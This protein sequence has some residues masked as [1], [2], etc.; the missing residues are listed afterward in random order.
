MCHRYRRGPFSDII[1]GIDYILDRFRASGVV[2]VVSMSL[3]GSP[4][5]AWDQAVQ[6]LIDHGVHVVVCV[7][8]FRDVR[9][10][11]DHIT[12]NIRL[13]PET[14]E[15]GTQKMQESIVLL[16]SKMPSPLAQALL[17]IQCG[18]SPA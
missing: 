4:S 7:D 2:P 6:S 14:V 12:N 8:S 16:E 10:Q 15:V 17:T 9:Q 3:G 13:L 5:E 18:A 1:A 11:S